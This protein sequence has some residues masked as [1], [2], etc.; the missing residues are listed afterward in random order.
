MFSRPVEPD[1]PI[2]AVYGQKAARYTWSMDPDNGFWLPIKGR[3]GL[4]QHRGTDFRC[5]IGTVVHA[6][7]DGLILRARYENPLDPSE[8][9]G[10]Y[11]LQLVSVPGYDN[12]VLRYSHLS[13]RHVKPGDK[14]YRGECIGETGDTGQLVEPFLHVDLMNVL[15]QWRAIPLET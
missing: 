13:K 1:Y 7:C 9:A 3:D 10:L 6:M 8:G 11:I 15:R 12:W 2:T 5:P 14:V 4:G